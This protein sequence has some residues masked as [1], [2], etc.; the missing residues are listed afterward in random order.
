[1]CSILT[2]ALPNNATSKY[3]I[4]VRAGVNYTWPYPLGPKPEFRS[5]PVGH[6]GGLTIQIDKTDNLAFAS[7]FVFVEESQYVEYYAS[8]EDL[9]RQKFTYYSIIL[10]IM[11]KW[12]VS[13]NLDLS[14]GPI[15]GYLFKATGRKRYNLNGKF[16][17]TNITKQLPRFNISYSFGIGP[18]IRY[19]GY[20]LSLELRYLIGLTIYR[21]V[22]YPWEWKNHSIQAG[23]SLTF[24]QKICYSY[25]A[26]QYIY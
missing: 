5:Y 10:P 6:Y 11:I 19:Q 2:F 22:R 12:K 15:F 24:K 18:N 26:Y 4:G 16:Y 17:K 20:M 3:K 21:N 14:T 13:R 8:Y 7:E 1:M 25:I 23:L 9:L